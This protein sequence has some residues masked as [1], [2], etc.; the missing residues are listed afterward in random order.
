MGKLV[1]L[2]LKKAGEKVFD[3]WALPLLVTAVTTG[4]GSVYWPLWGFWWGSAI[5]ASFGCAVAIIYGSWKYERTVGDEKRRREKNRIAMQEVLAGLDATE[6]N[7]LS[8]FRSNNT[9]GCELTK[10]VIAGLLTKNVVV[11]ASN[12]GEF[13]RFPVMLSPMAKK[14]LES[15]SWSLLD[16]T[17]T[18]T[19]KHDP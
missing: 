14:E 4:I 12:M 18:Q 16:Q 7:V 6:L 3:R 15:T 11:R 19:S 10:P 1:L 5:A 9:L 17:N 13:D 8:K 2:V